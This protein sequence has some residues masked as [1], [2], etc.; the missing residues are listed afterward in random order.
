MKWFAIR[1]VYYRGEEAPGRSVYE[2]RSVLYR[3]ETPEAAFEL[4]EEDNSQYLKLNPTLKRVGNPGAFQLG[5]TGDD[6][7]RAEVWSVLGA[8]PLAPD[9]YFR[10][11]YLDIEFQPEDQ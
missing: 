1:T 2:E 10:R 3:A 6:L 11:H 8:S 7:H 9:E 4:A 5:E